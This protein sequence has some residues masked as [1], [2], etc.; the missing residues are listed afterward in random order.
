NYE[1]VKITNEHVVSIQQATKTRFEIKTASGTTFHSIKIL[2]TTG[3]RDE[4]PNI[5]NIEKFYGTSLF[6]C[7]Y[8]DGWELRDQPLAVIADKN[9]YKLAKEVYM[10]SHDLVV[11][12]NG[13]GHL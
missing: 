6:S 11:L 13:E 7:P 10:W 5:P 12:T 3:L 1:S 2:L 8:C 9:V 4:Q